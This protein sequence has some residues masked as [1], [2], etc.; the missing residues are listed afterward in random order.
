MPILEEDAL[1]LSRSIDSLPESEKPWVNG[2][3]DE[4]KA[5]QERAGMPLYPQ[6]ER[7]QAEQ[8]RSL[9]TGGLK[10]VDSV[11]KGITQQLPYEKDADAF[12]ART[13]NTAFLSKRTGIPA[14]EIAAAY[15]FHRDQYAKKWGDYGEQNDVSFYNSAANEIQTEIKQERLSGDA[16]ANGTIAASL[17]EDLF[18][19]LSNWHG[20][21]KNDPVYRPEM[22]Q[23]FIEAYG[24]IGKVRGTYGWAADQF[25]EALQREKQGK[26][27]EGDDV[28]M[29][30]FRN[31][32]IDM[33]PEDQRATLEMMSN[34][35]MKLGD[36]Q[37]MGVMRSMGEGLARFVTADT[38]LS[39]GSLASVS[40]TPG[41]VTTTI[42]AITNEAEA[43]AFVKEQADRSEAQAF[44]ALSSSGGAGMGYIPPT[45]TERQL[46]ESEAKLVATAK[47]RAQKAI[48]VGRQIRAI[49]HSTDPVGPIAGSVGTSIGLMGALVAGGAAALP[50]IAKT[51]TAND[52]E[53]IRLEHPDI[54]VSRARGIALASG[55]AEAALDAWD[56]KIFESLPN[57]RNLMAGGLKKELL[58]S[59][60]RSI[61]GGIVAENLQEAAQD[62]V[63][64]ILTN[65]LASDAS[66]VDWKADVAD[67]AKGRVDTFF[68]ILPLIMVGTGVATVRDF[69][70][71]RSELVSNQHLGEAGFVEAD[72]TAIL[73]AA[74]TGD[75]SKI[76]A[77]IQ[78]AMPRRMVE[79]A[80][81]FGGE[82]QAQRLDSQRIIAKAE[83]LGM[84][85]RIR[86]DGAGLSVHV[87]EN[88]VRVDNWQQAQA[89]VLGHLSDYERQQQEAI[90]SVAGE[91]IDRGTTPEAWE[92]S[93]H[94]NRTL[95][96]EVDAGNVT[97]DQARE[98][99]RVANQ[100]DGLNAA[101]SDLSTAAVLG[102][103]TAEMIDT[104]RTMVS[105][106]FL[107]GSALTPVEE[108]IE[109]RWK[110][111]LRTGVYSQEQGAAWVRM[112]EEAMG[113]TLLPKDRAAS[114]RELL[115]AISSVIV[116]DVVGR[117]KDGS[118]FAPGVIS[119]GLAAQA[120]GYRQRAGQAAGEMDAQE[121]GKF[122]GFLRA[123]RALIGQ[124][125]R[126]GRAL[127]RARAEGKLGDGYE[128]FLDSLIG[129][130][131][132][133]RYSAEVEKAGNAL[134]GGHDLEAGFMKRT[135]TGE[136]RAET[137]FSLSRARPADASN[138]TALPDGATLVGPT[139]FSITAHHGTPHKVDKFSLDKIGTGEGAQAFGWGLYFAENKNVAGGYRAIG[140]DGRSFNLPD[141]P[142]HGIA[143]ILAN[144]GD[145]EGEK[146]ARKA[147]ASL[148]DQ[149]DSVIQQA[150]DAIDSNSNL[151]TVDLLPD[152]SE[153]LDWDKPLTEQSE[154][155]RDAL[156]QLNITEDNLADEDFSEQYGNAL[157]GEAIS[158]RFPGS[159][160]YALA[161]EVVA[162]VTEKEASHQRT[163][164][165]LARL[166]IP[167]VKYLDGGSRGKGDGTRNFVL[168][169]H[170]LVKI[171]EENGK[172]V[173]NL[174][175]TSFSLA[176][177]R[178]LDLVQNRLR[179]M[180]DA[181]P[182][183]T[184]KF[185]EKATD[186]LRKLRSQW[187]TLPVPQSKAQL[188][189]AQAR[190]VEA[191][192]DELEEKLVGQIEFETGGLSQMPEL[193]KL[194]EH[195]LAALLRTSASSRKR[196][197]GWRLEPPSR[198]RARQL[199]QFGEISGDYDGSDGLPR[200]WF[201]GSE[202]PDQLAEEAFE[203]NLISEPTPVGLWEGIGK[204]LDDVATNK[205]R[206]HKVQDR[207]REAKESAKREA[208]YE[209]KAWRFEQ[210]AQQ[211]RL[212]NVRQAA[213]R[214]VAMLEAVTAA[215][216]SAVRDKLPRGMAA[217][218]GI[219]SDRAFAE[220]IHRRIRKIDGALMDHW[221]EQNAESLARLLARAQ[222]K[223]E[224]GKKP[225]G[226]A[227]VAVHEY[228]EYASK[229]VVMPGPELVGEQAKVEAAME[230][231]IG[232]NEEAQWIEKR[233]ILDTW[234]GFNSMHVAAQSE[235]L[236]AGWEFYNSGRRDW[237]ASE[238]QRLQ[239]GRE[240]SAAMVEKLG[241]GL[242][243]KLAQGQS[244]TA[245]LGR[246]AVE[247]R[248]FEGVLAALLGRDHPLTVRWAGDVS[249]GFA[250]K[251]DGMRALRKRWQFALDTAMPGLSK[252]K[253]KLRLYEMR[254]KR[255]IAVEI[256][257][258]KANPRLS[259]NDK[260]SLLQL[261][262]QPELVASKVKLTEDEA[263]FLTMTARQSQYR[264]ALSLAGWNPA[265][266][267][268]VEAAL[269][270]EAKSLRE[271]MASEYDAGH[272]PLSA[273]FERVRGL[274]LP[275]ITNYSPGRFY[276]WGN[277]KPLDV[278]GTGTVSGGFADGFLVDRKAHFA[279][280]KLAS[281]L[282][283]FW[284]H[285]NESLHWQALAEPV[286]EMRGTL[287]HPDVKRAVQGAWG[288]E[289]M[290]LL[291]SWMQAIEGNGIKHN[292]GASEKL[293]AWATSNFAVGKLAYNAA[294][295][296]KQSTAALNVAL[297][298]PFGMFVMGA[299][300]VVKNPG[301]FLDVYNSDTIQRRMETGYSPEVRMLLDKFWTSK[302]GFTQ[303]AMERGMEALGFADAFFTSISAAVAYEGHA[304]AA[305]KAGM[306]SEQ[307]HK[308]G[309]E[310]M[311]EAV[312]RTAQP[313]TADRRSIIE[314]RASGLGKLAILFMTEARQKSAIWLEA[315][316][317][318]GGDVVRK[319]KGN[320][321]RKA[322]ARDVR[323]LIISHMILAPM[324]AA[325]SAGIRDWRDGPDDG[326]DDPAWEVSDFAIAALIGP[327]QGLP[328]IG[329]LFGALSDAVAGRR[330]MSKASNVLAD[331][332][333][334][335]LVG[336]G[337]LLT[338]TFDE[339]EHS[340]EDEAAKI[341][342][343]MQNVG[344]VPGV[345]ANI[346]GQLGDAV[347]QASGEKPKKK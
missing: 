284:T 265:K 131:Q 315:W 164:R 6:Q 155:V 198:W 264:E 190:I 47:E 319:A 172:P 145:V 261:G 127:M 293:I 268:E 340:A 207:I 35:A 200:V 142:A 54:P 316:Q 26:A 326:D 291:E 11:A 38:S 212:G 148:G 201:Q 82:A 228:F 183:G 239:R 133:A 274:K 203:E 310:K 42:P 4:Y 3:L 75:D 84:L 282:G 80:A 12:R 21:A 286:R 318:V 71:S 194:T 177:S 74:R 248:D 51:Y 36:K 240:A 218:A 241:Q 180:M 81:E 184:R 217:L 111:G 157:F 314:H 100:L 150:R 144:K 300:E 345:V 125:M 88:F 313:Q 44:S 307:A 94:E 170:D 162:E 342:R 332:V 276:N 243:E 309:M 205:E 104:V 213:V 279:Q 174:G 40:T 48:E 324:M 97:E 303:D 244:I 167:G 347:D 53:Q 192:R 28:V 64:P 219:T 119:R 161:G 52:Y 138:Q 331:P 304:R 93:P 215:L 320:K 156:A 59:A 328:L 58:A 90:A 246:I 255:K 147:Y 339:K 39:E 335:V 69:H 128:S 23:H 283:V 231:A 24:R 179:L 50:V 107:Q 124:A 67:Y 61:A 196:Y 96:N 123:W 258:E 70:T 106:G 19:S 202:S 10:G 173:A 34:K 31:T 234:G 168:F 182:E 83:E 8:F 140:K 135:G 43:R 290:Q 92:Q 229:V 114:P 211:Q 1:K 225:Q 216:P 344:G 232:S 117:R 7:K 262:I 294:T 245:T 306:S 325:I 15:E 253:Q 14:E 195:P 251:D 280:V 57:L 181:K 110:E 299:G 134:M 176:P 79:V 60:G 95:K 118:H 101:E 165:Y 199:E 322:T 305:E 329:Q 289:G 292:A 103:N 166:G 65:A 277:E 99:V 37:D 175:A 301:R 120:L 266:L 208:E 346:A 271:W 281:A 5:Q 130:S 105:R 206:L 267:A 317:H 141:G 108:I 337:D 238:M 98:A 275:K 341:L 178:R 250:Q 66:S 163:S 230:A 55:F 73:E 312:A 233:Q 278:M 109:G 227:G 68:S 272:A 311:A 126:R 338:D 78:E 153:F 154:K 33:P 113:E 222:G 27:K 226:T 269:S 18:S 77:A 171:I 189:R 121:V 46:T 169:D 159:G 17:G 158:P 29:Q 214:D 257:E 87:G 256:Q 2:V 343:I 263:L 89:L 323:A 116:A 204:M 187:A 139:T 296:V 285:Q 210:D 76:Q 143:I 86:R 237:I 191:R 287:R 295:M 72:R 247:V 122:R 235:V 236:D 224:G 186:N 85:P 185:I 62:A 160:L 223:R 25:T 22:L 336:A 333:S 197:Y 188:D 137:S 308:V 63:L 32:L 30:Q 209:G 41:T 297:D 56:I 260:E 49:A 91:L 45:G 259:T 270:P 334:A 13:A 132:E 20:G 9:F 221:K 146:I 136:S 288:E 249:R 298:M 149:L 330:I 193:A 16:M 102:K 327:L 302:P 115:E 242:Y 220:E 151:Y 273:V 254:T 129:M 252:R 152:E 112:A 321:E